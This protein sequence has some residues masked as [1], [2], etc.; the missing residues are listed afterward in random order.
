MRHYAKRRLCQTRPVRRSL[1]SAYTIIERQIG[2]STERRAAEA[3]NEKCRNGTQPT[4]LRRWQQYDR[5]SKADCMGVDFIFF[6]DVGR[7][8]LNTKSSTVF[9]KAFELA[10]NRNIVTA[11]VDVRKDLDGIYQD[12]I[13]PVAKRRDEII[14][15]R[16][17][18]HAQ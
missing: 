12:I 3:L 16:A 7:I 9:A 14:A 8:F 18:R 6:T 15:Y 11:V 10:G 4:W 17:K 2:E 13:G 1:S 5:S